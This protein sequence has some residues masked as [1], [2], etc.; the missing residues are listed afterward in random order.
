MELSGKTMGI[1][2]FGRIGRQTGR[3]ADAMGMRVIA[4]DTYH[5]DEPA[6]PEFRWASVEEVLRE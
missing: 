4:N 6:W 1:V 5:G 3:I 2:G